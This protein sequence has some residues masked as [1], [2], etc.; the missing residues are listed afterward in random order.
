MSEIINNSRKRIDELKSLLKQ[1]NEGK[2][3]SE[4][5][6]ELT[7]LFGSIP[8]GD[9]VQAEQE[10]I[11]EGMPVA[12]I[13]KY[14]DAHSEALKDKIDLTF[15]KHVPEGHPVSI[16]RKENLAISD[17]V[18]K[19]TEILINLK[20][21][22]E[23]PYYYRMSF[24]IRSILNNLMDIEKHYSKKE[25]LFFPYLEKYEITGPTSV[26]WGK[27]D[28]VREFLK[29]SL[30]VFSQEAEITKELLMEYSGFLFK[31]TYDAILEMIEKEEKILF[32]MCLDKFTDLD[33]K[34]I[35]G[36]IDELGYCLISP[37][38]KWLSDD[39]KEVK[40]EEYESGKVKFS[41]GSFTPEE[42]EAMINSFPLDI[43]FVDK[44]DTVKYFSHGSTRIFDR[45]KAILGRK[46]QFCHP[47]SSVH[48]VE[49]I[50]NDFKSGKQNEAKFW[51][52]FKGMFVHIAYYAVR[53]PEGEYLGTVEVTQNID[54]FKAAEGERR[55]LSY[56]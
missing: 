40:K 55:L 35:A 6:E 38:V 27:D 43:T 28:E 51:I 23:S 4:V 39:D 48:I 2:E 22:N 25:N 9:V 19:L 53:N 30:G 29:S 1:L 33:W 13:Q 41:T 31:P 16:M 11:E 18:A 32:P 15:Q 7:G 44:D 34:E 21:K 26:M 45:S 54:E 17:E 49:K 10:L 47:P 3:L 12:E 14:C 50:L 8:Y 52:N 46:V 56:E 42:L 24:E 20:I 37:D 5:R 36:Q